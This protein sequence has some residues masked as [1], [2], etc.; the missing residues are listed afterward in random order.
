MKKATKFNIK[1]KVI[2]DV[3]FSTVHKFIEL[4]QNNDPTV[5]FDTWIE[6]QANEYYNI[7]NKGK[8]K[9]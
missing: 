1:E 4:W 6:N 2:L 8:E 3:F 5:T 7:K 9:K